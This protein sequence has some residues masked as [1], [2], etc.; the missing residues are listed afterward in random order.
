MVIFIAS[1]GE[2]GCCGETV[3]HKVAADRRHCGGAALRISDDL[4]DARRLLSPVVVIRLDALAPDR[5]NY[6]STEE[7]SFRIFRLVK[8]AT[9]EVD[10]STLVDDMRPPVYLIGPA[11]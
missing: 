3:V 9:D 11:V 8:A 10:R 2:F 1:E 6:R 4:Q 5:G 7:H